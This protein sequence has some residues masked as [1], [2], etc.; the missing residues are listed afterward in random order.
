MHDLE[1]RIRRMYGRDRAIAVLLLVVPIS[2]ALL[3]QAFAM[4]VLGMAVVHAKRL[5]DD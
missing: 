4:L 3:H 5:S 1:P 2:A